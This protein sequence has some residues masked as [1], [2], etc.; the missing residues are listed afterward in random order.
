[1]RKATIAEFVEDADTLALL[2]RFGVDMV[3]RFLP[4]HR[5]QR[6]PGGGEAYR[7]TDGRARQVEAAANEVTYEG[8][9]FFGR[10]FRRK[11]GLA[12]AQYRKRF[13]LLRRALRTGTA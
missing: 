4:R 10:L 3:Q 6:P 5:A 9:S 13:G 2:K 7:L 12:P 1:M 11:V 8:S